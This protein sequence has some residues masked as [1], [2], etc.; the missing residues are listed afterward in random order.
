[1]NEPKQ[2]PATLVMAL[3]GASE[4]ETWQNVADA[5]QTQ[6]LQRFMTLRA[7]QTNTPRLATVSDEAALYHT[8]LCRNTP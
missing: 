1:M 7:F 5:E 8:L 2:D 6:T 4:A 3:F